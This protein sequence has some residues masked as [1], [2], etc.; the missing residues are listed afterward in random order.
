MAVIDSVCV[1][2]L[3]SR[4]ATTDLNPDYVFL[5]LN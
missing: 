3:S 4:G 2:I 5:F 1:V